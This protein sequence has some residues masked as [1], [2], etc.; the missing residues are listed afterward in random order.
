MSLLVLHALFSLPRPPHASKRVPPSTL[1][2]DL[3]LE[4]PVSINVVF[5]SFGPTEHHLIIRDDPRLKV[6]PIQHKLFGEGTE[7]KKEIQVD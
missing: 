2:I 6:D 3:E 5:E 7:G 4:V 1:I